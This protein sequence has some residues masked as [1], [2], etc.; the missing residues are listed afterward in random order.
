MGNIHDIILSFE[1]E[2]AAQGFA[3]HFSEPIAVEEVKG[4]EAALGV[5]FPTEYVNFI[6]THGLLVVELLR[7]GDFLFE[8]LMPSHAVEDM[9]YVMDDEGEQN[10]EIAIFQKFGKQDIFEFYAFQ[11]DGAVVSYFDDGAIIRPVAPN[12]TQ[13]IRILLQSIID[14]SY[15]NR[16]TPDRVYD[17]QAFDAGEQAQKDRA[18]MLHSI[19]EAGK[20]LKN[21]DKERLIKA[22][23]LY[24]H[25]IDYLK[26]GKVKDDHYWASTHSLCQWACS[27][28]LA[29]HRQQLTDA[30]VND[31]RAQLI[32]HAQQALALTPI[33]S[34]NDYYNNI[35]RSASNA[36]AWHMTVNTQQKDLLE[37]GLTI[38][39]QGIDQIE[40]S[41]HYFIY[42]TQVRI[43]LKLDRKEEAYRIVHR[44]TTEVPGFSDF[45][46]FTNNEE[47]QGW[48]RHQG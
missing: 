14:G 6:T 37:K 3:I 41:Q 18:D 22:L 32:E 21:A 46:D 9:E 19:Q 27:S 31:F 34:G 24:N 4:A 15:R 47:Y 38:V 44:V 20:L 30:E 11:R 10:R 43:L 45:Q 16:H 12:F 13:H 26:T 8:M 39:Q 40:T 5:A 48:V 23:G 1:K 36:L 29:N 33:N 17:K 28:L 42:D 7:T 25:A 2:I 35:I